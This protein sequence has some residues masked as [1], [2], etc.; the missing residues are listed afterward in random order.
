MTFDYD[1]SAESPDSLIMFVDNDR[2]F[3]YT[4]DVTGSFSYILPKGEH[5]VRWIFTKE[6]FR[7][8]KRIMCLSETYAL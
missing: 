8:Q 5:T 7:F 3:G 4:D 6:K 1:I 2:A